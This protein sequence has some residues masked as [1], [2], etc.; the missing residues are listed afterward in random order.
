MSGMITVLLTSLIAAIT[1]MSNRFFSGER[2]KNYLEFF[3]KE[4]ET[5]IEHLRLIGSK[6]GGV[7]EDTRLTIEEIYDLYYKDVYHFAIYYTNRRD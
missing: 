6:G 3:Y 1:N 5:N 2:Q 4:I 7:V